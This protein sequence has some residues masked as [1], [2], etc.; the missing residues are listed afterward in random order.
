MSDELLTI[1]ETAEYLKVSDKTIRRLIQDETLIASKIGRSWRVKKSD[2]ESYYKAN[3]NVE[4][5]GNKT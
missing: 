4:K 2:I 3:T 1:A 5:G